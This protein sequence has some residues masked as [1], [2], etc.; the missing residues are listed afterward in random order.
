M[1]VDRYFTI[2]LCINNTIYYCANTH[3]LDYYFAEGTF[4]A[5]ATG[6]AT[7]A[8]VVDDGSVADSADPYE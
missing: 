1:R 7:T 5:T 8:V 3:S 2:Y 4:S 6:D